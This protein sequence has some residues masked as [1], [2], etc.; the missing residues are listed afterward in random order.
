[1][2][3]I[4]YT[5]LAITLASCNFLDDAPQGIMTQEQA[6]SEVEGLVT[7]AYSALGNDHY[8]VPFSLWPYGNVRSDDAY[9]GGSDT[10]DI[11]AFHFYETS[12]NIDP[13]FAEADKLWFNCY[14]AISRTN[15]ALAALQKISEADLPLKN[16]R[17]G[18]MY[19]L[20]G[21]FYFMLKQVFGHIPFVDENTPD[22]EYEKTPNTLPNDEQ[23][24]WITNDFKKAYDLL[25]PSQ[26]Q[27]G[28]ANK[29]AAATYLAKAFL[30]KAYR[31]DQSNNVTSID[32]TDLDQVLKYTNEVL[33]SP[34]GLE[35][36]FA[37]NFLPGGY[38]NGKESIF[39]VQYSAEDG[40]MYGR[41]NW[42]D[43]LSAPQKVGCCDFHKPS[44]NLVNAFKTTNGVPQFDT[45]NTNNYNLT[46]DKTD[47]RLFHTVA[48]PG[49]PYKYNT[50]LIY[51][52]DWNRNVNVYGVY[53]SLKENVDP[54]CSCFK[55]INPFRGNSKNRIVLRYA[56]VLLMRAEA[57]IELNRHEEALQYINQVRQRAAQSISLIG[58]APNIQIATYVPGANITWKQEVA[59]QA[60]RWERR[61]EFAMEGQRF[62]DLVRWGI[63]DEV[64][65]TYYTTEATRRPVIYSNARF[66][67]NKNEYIPIPQNQIGYVRGIYKQNV[68][69]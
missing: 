60:L 68:G 43:V 33:S 14:K 42:G 3:K 48:I 22:K 44:Q 64:M 10:S 12:Q 13:T 35:D 46:S 19:F 17:M 66:T 36:D 6:Q 28:R 61:L 32:A 18:E 27:K 15:T 4:L 47:P 67:K 69:F 62:F 8:D 11:Q 49:L 24:A 52:E 23:W 16:V 38:E 9:K 26:T 5:T 50:E 58:Y 41:L 21:H 55:N 63:A 57:L 1:M 7:A 59:R 45:Y 53:A 30:Y 29:Y 37:F 40:T 54:S 51:Q 25:P 31:Q 34:Y 2:K 65:N 20:R 56:D 39:A